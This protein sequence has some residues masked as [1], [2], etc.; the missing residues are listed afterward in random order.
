MKT[1]SYLKMRTALSLIFVTTSFI[2]D[3]SSAFFKYL[4]DCFDANGKF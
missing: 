2:K 3:K 4:I 1:T